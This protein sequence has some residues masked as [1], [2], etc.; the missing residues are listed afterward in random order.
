MV[1]KLV[2]VN[3]YL[4]IILSFST[5]ILSPIASPPADIKSLKPQL[6]ELMA[7]RPS[8]LYLGNHGCMPFFLLVKNKVV[9]AIVLGA[10]VPT[11]RDNVVLYAPEDEAA[12]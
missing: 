5:G 4:K 11:L 1:L 8:D 6:V 3:V 7:T 12:E 9:V 2:S 10:D